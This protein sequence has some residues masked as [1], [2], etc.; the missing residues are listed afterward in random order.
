MRT[1][2]KRENPKPKTENRKTEKPKQQQQQQIECRR[3]AR[4]KEMENGGEGIQR[5]GKSNIEFVVNDI[6]KHFK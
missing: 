1:C 6:D 2:Q 3:A 5:G 4:V